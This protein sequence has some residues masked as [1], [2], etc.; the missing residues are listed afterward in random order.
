MNIFSDENKVKSNWWQK[1]QIGDSIEG[2]LISKRTV[3][4]QLRN[5]DQTVYELKVSSLVQEGKPVAAIGEFWNVGG[6]FGIDQQ[7]RNVKLG[8]IIGFKFTEERKPSKPGLNPTK[9]VQ[10]Y[11]NPKVVDEQWIKEQAEQ[12]EVEANIAETEETVAPLDT[13]A[14]LTRIDVLA[15]EKL[16]AVTPEDVKNKTM[17]YTGLAFIEINLPQIVQ[18]LEQLPKK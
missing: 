10:V 1:K 2:T 14:M 17:E 15:K 9:V 5:Q 6:T 18:M 11:A 7:M 13:S 8:Q 16:G 4:N 12:M 3:L